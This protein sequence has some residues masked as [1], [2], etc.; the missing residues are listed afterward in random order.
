M[1]LAAK[2]QVRRQRV[3]FPSSQTGYTGWPAPGC[4]LPALIAMPGHLRLFSAQIVHQC[5]MPCTA[6]PPASQSLATSVLP[7]SWR[8]RWRSYAM[9]ALSWLWVSC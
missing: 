7:P 1:V 2:C 5:V 3:V 9:P 8:R 4:L 6:L